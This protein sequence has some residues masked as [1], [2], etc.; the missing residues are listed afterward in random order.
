MANRKISQFAKIAAGSVAGNDLVPVVDVSGGATDGG[1]RVMEIDTFRTLVGSTEASVENAVRAEDARDAAATSAA[2][3]ALFKGPKVPSRAALLADTALTYTPAQP[4]TVVAGDYVNTV[5]DR[6][7]YEVVDEAATDF[8]DETDGGVKVTFPSAAIIGRKPF[9]SV[10]MGLKDSKSLDQGDRLQYAVN[11]AANEKVGRLDLAGGTIIS[12]RPIYG[13]HDAVN[14]PDFVDNGVPVPF[15]IRG[16]GHTNRQC[17]D[18]DVDDGA[19]VL[20]FTDPAADCLIFGDGTNTSGNKAV[21]LA[22]FSVIADTAG[23]ALLVDYAPQL[24]KISDLFL[25]NVGA[26][27]GLRLRSFWSCSVE[28]LD[29]YGGSSGAEGIGLWLDNGAGTTGGGLNFIKNV[30]ASY[31]EIA[32]RFGNPFG[33]NTQ[34]RVNTLVALQGRHSKEGLNFGQGFHG[35]LLNTWLENNEVC[36]LRMADSCSGLVVEGLHNGSPS[37]TEGTV[38]FGRASGSADARRYGPAS[39]TNADGLRCPSGKGGIRRYAIADY[40]PLYL[41]QIRF[42]DN[43]D[44]DGTG[45]LVDAGDKGGITLGHAVNFSALKAGRKVGNIAGNE[46]WDLVRGAG[47]EMRTASGATVDMSALKSMPER[48]RCTTTTGASTILLPTGFA[49]YA[50]Y[51]LSTEFLKYQTANDLVLDAGTGNTIKGAQTYTIAGGAAYKG[52]KLVP[53]PVYTGTVITSIRWDVAGEW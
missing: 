15:S 35:K 45:I 28:D 3:A 34:M 20:K 23:S 11:A 44:T 52:I 10:F 5:G 38:V 42:D 8:L 2:Q 17:Y 30:T 33:S 21:R 9:D 43:G 25:A 4:S 7:A 26:G 27:H 22:D 36:D 6:F 29:I 16:I 19:T 31:F 49:D 51:S 47:A 13:L 46:R 40:A 53:S 32:Q 48:M 1:N 41:D 39:I 50:G 18:N 37:V 14:N 24:S 12:E